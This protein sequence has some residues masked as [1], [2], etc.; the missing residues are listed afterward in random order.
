MKRKKKEFVDLILISAKISIKTKEKKK[1]SHRCSVDVEQEGEN[2]TKHSFNL[3]G[4]KLT[5]ANSYNIPNKPAIYKPQVNAYI[6]AHV[7]LYLVF[8]CH[9]LIFIRLISG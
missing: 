7:L 9:R 5:A 3:G 4:K 8:I 2:P 6:A 1:S